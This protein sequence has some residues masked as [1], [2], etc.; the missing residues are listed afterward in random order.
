MTLLSRT[1]L[2]KGL[3]HAIKTGPVQEFPVRVMQ[4]GEGNF[5]RAFIDWMFD[6]LNQKGLFNGMVTMVQPIAQGMADA[7][8]AQ[9]G[10]YTL[11]L[12]GVQNGQ[13]VQQQQVITCVKNCLNPYT[14]WQA[15]TATACSPDLR[16]VFS[17]TTEAGIAYAPEAYVPGQT[18]TTYPAKLTAL[19]YQ[20][21]QKFHGAADKGLIFVPCELIDK[22]GATLR[23]YMLQYAADWKLEPAFTDWLKSANTFVNT[24]VDRIVAGYPRNEIAGIL[25]QLGYEDKLVDCGEI[26][27]FFVIEGPKALAKELPYDQIGLNVCWTDNQTPYRTRKVRFLNGAHTSSITGAFL[28]GCDLVDEMMDDKVFGQFVE[29]AIK[30]EIYCTVPLPD[31]EKTFFANSILERFRNPFAGHQLLSISLNSTSKWK[32]RVEPSLLDYVKIKGQLPKAL[33]FSMASLICFYQAEKCGDGYVG[34]CRSNPYPIKDD[35]DRVEFMSQ[36]WKQ[37]RQDQDSR[38]LAA[39]VL[40]Q[41]AWWEMDLNTVS[42]LTDYVANAIASIKTVGMRAAVKKMLAEK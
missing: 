4:F 14:E 36:A 27:H 29:T 9:D 39:A 30:D 21:F 26:F 40:G 38:K 17:N 28:G 34:K 37:W 31:D 41:T 13:V 20:R 15:V 8:N 25:A 35:A 10:L 18:P 23:Q 11:L 1:L 3:P 12:R 42:G 24:L 16:F 5:L 32:V 22:N 19:L 33:A 2:K 6:E 7:I